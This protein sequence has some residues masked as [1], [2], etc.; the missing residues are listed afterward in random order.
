MRKI[1]IVVMLGVF[2]LLNTAFAADSGYGAKGALNTPQPT[3]QEML[4]FAI[5]DEYLARNQ[6]TTIVDTFGK[7]RPFSNIVISEERHIAYLQPLFTDRGWDIPTDKSQTHVIK[8]KTFPEALNIG[9]QT[10]T[11][12]IAMY[13]YFLQQRELPSDLKTTFEL[14]L[15]ASK[16]HLQAF[17]K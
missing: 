7:V 13:E 15:A 17:S 1:F 9:V 5:Q 14:L 3:V 4:N 16:K 11:D 8:V 6:Y 10:E 12:N 2:M